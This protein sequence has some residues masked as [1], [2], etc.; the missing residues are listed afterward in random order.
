M[1]NLCK[2]QKRKPKYASSRNSP[3]IKI[4]N[5]NRKVKKFCHK[6]TTSGKIYKI[7]QNILKDNLFESSLFL[8]F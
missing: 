2:T 1:L 3:S 5:Q 8:K 4:D 6:K 7:T